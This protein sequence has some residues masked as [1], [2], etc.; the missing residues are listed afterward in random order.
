MP[1]DL[2]RNLRRIA[3][4]A[5]RVLWNALKP[6]RDQGWHFRRQV[7][8][9]SYIAD[10]ACLHANL[11]IEV[12]GPT[13]DF[14]YVADADRDEYMRSRGINVLHFSNDDVLNNSDGVFEAIAGVLNAVSLTSNTPTPAPSPQ[15]GGEPKQRRPRR[16]R[17]RRPADDEPAEGLPVGFPSPLRGGGRGGGS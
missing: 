4:K 6:L 8:I 16:P 9:G 10:F 15:G 2:A 7:P 13:H 1:T 5:E 17:T 11:V 14:T 3:P 12:D